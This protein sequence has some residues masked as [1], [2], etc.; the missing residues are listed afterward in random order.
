MTKLKPQLKNASE[1]REIL[2]EATFPYTWQG[3]TVDV[4]LIYLPCNNGKCDVASLFT[5]IKK[6]LMANFVLSYSY[7]NRKLALRKAKSDEDL[8]KI[9]VQ[10]ISKNTAH[11]ELG[12][13]LLFTLLDIYLGA[14]KIISKISMKTSSQ[15]PVF[16]A[17]A[18]HAQY[19]DGKVSLYLGESKLYKSFKDASRDAAKSIAT[20]LENYQVEFRH[21]DAHMDFE[22]ISDVIRDELITML[23]PFGEKFNVTETLYSP[24]FIGFE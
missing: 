7:I 19:V 10:Y 15:M 2:K 4:R 11:G 12:E 22:G 18:I 23:D 16:G 1:I 8:F 20:A 5:V 24:C 14:P 6:C 21:I 17:D 9:A 13:L 3:E